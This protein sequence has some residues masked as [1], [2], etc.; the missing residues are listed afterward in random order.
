MGVVWAR[1]TTLCG[2]LTTTGGNKVS[3]MTCNNRGSAQENWRAHG[4]RSEGITLELPLG[5][6]NTTAI[7]LL[8]CSILSCSQFLHALIIIIAL[9]SCIIQ[10]LNY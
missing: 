4:T 6:L 3:H 7:I 5:V 9:P 10:C 8:F 2:T 1:K